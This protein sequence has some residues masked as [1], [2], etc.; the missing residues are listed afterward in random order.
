[1]EA[2][3]FRVIVPVDGIQQGVDFY[4]A[5][6]GTPGE[7][8]SGGRH[9]FQCGPVVLALVDPASER[10]PF[11]PNPD[12]LYLAVADLED[13]LGRAK[14]AGATVEVDIADYS[15]GERSFYMRDPF[16]NPLCF[17]LNETMFTGGRFVD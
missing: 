5:L 2:S 12:W 8:V 15:W 17:V 4:A 13:A 14:A 10:Q 6:F 7:R 9:Y 3:I 16:G 11:R 1:M